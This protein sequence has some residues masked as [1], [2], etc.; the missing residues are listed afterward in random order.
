MDRTLS[1]S[2]RI[3]RKLRRVAGPALGLGSLAL[4]FFWLTGLLH[5]SLDR[6]RIR[7]ATVERHALEAVLTADGTVQP[8][9]EQ[10]LASPVA[11]RVLR[12]LRHPGA[13]LEVG[14]PILDLDAT[15]TRLELD[16]LEGEIARAESRR[17]ELQWSLEEMINEKSSREEIKRLDLEQMS[18]Q[19]EQ[20]RELFEQGLVSE[21][22]LKH[23]AALTE[24]ARIELATI[25]RSKVN[26]QRTFEE[27]LGSLD[28][29]LEIRRQEAE[30]TRVR[31]ERATTEADR[32]G[33]LTWVLDQ[34]GA[35]V[36][37]GDVLARIADLG[38]FRIEATLSDVHAPRLRV[39]QTARVVVAGETLDA[40]ISRI[41]PAVER[42]VVRFWL[43]LAEGDH[44]LLRSNLRV[45]ALVVTDRLDNA[46]TIAKGP[47][48]NGTGAQRIFVIDGE[49]AVRREVTIGLAG[50][51]RYEV[52]EGLREG[53]TV[54]ISDVSDFLHLDELP[55][56]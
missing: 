42:G 9:A 49:R 43:E 30:V 6:E 41:F 37:E 27:Q 35:V 33:V 47:F 24:K 1:T 5:P 17:R 34:E 21:G 53:E 28:S 20:Q 10:V 56:K 8:A 36:R 51:S 12:V 40:S 50:W 38:R 2:T 31:L 46:L 29:E 52:Q 4:L 25:A 22:T 54:V 3:H 7:T 26:S 45:D 39:G 16:R 23:S 32:R 11:G 19:E 13:V 15:E 14:D 48:A 18:Y 44:E 55:L